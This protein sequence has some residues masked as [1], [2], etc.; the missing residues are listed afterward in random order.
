MSHCG[1]VEGLTGATM[2][3]SPTSD[4]GV[5][6]RTGVIMAAPPTSNASL[7]HQDQPQPEYSENE[8]SEEEEEITIIFRNHDIAPEQRSAQIWDKYRRDFP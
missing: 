7:C 1:G 8:T 4:S 3:E 5:E 6:G 2:G